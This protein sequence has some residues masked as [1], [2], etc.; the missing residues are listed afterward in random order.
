VTRAVSFDPGNLAPN[1]VTFLLQRHLATLSVVRPNGQV[2]VSPVGFTF[3]PAT[4]IARVITSA[5]ARKSIHSA[6]AGRVS[7]CQVD[8]GNWL[9]LEGDVRVSADPEEVADAEA[10]Y[11]HR[12]KAP[13]ANPT[14]VV[15][16]VNVDRLYGRVV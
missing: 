7:L 8:G 1:V 2:H 11:T 3:D 12:Y 9:T 5:T 15:L 14:R 13:R 10:R 16:V 4:G 6:A